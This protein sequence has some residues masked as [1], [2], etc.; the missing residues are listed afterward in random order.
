MSLKVLT[1]NI[2]FGCMAAKKDWNVAKWDRT[3][4]DLARLCENDQCVENVAAS[5][6]TDGPW[7]IVALQEATNYEGVQAKSKQLVDMD[8]VSGIAEKE[9]I[10]TFVNKYKFTILDSITGD[11]GDFMGGKWHR[12][13][14]RAF[15]LTHLQEIDTG[16]D[17]I[18]ANMHLGHF[19]GIK[20]LVGTD[21]VS[22]TVIKVLVHELS[23]A[24]SKFSMRSDGPPTVVFA[25]DFNDGGRFRLWEGFM[26]FSDSN[27]EHLKTV[28][29]HT[30]GEDGNLAI[31][32]PTCCDASNGG[33]FQPR[34]DGKHYAYGDYIMSNTTV[35]NKLQPFTPPASD[36][37][38]VAGEV[39]LMRQFMEQDQAPQYDN[40]GGARKSTV[41]SISVVPLLLTSVAMAVLGSM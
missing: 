36:H 8:H 31:P 13:A 7:D 22:D 23:S 15:Q 16:A 12:Q 29:V 24:V 10:A 19:G 33:Q 30:L 38:P 40:V 37:R 25:G 4:I 17:V 11:M 32:P 39:Q 9:E 1:Y 41:F 21:K 34:S 35:V 3:A 14:G 27:I 20:K 5:I 26:P 2:C 28:M 6:D 18:V